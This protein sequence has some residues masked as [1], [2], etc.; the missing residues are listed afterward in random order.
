MF[1]KRSASKEKAIR[2]CSSL[3]IGVLKN[4]AMFTGKYLCWSLF[5]IKLQRPATVLKETSTQVFFCKYCEIF[6]NSFFYRPL[7]VAASASTTP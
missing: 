4:F 5:L 7:L 3:K 2:K 6:K 1:K